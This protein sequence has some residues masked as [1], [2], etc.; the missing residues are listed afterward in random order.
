VIA[1]VENGS[2]AL[3]AFEHLYT[4]GPATGEV[5]KFIDFVVSP[6]FQAEL[7]RLGFIPVARLAQR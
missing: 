6:E 7:P 3:W 2:H 4:R 5:K 1:V